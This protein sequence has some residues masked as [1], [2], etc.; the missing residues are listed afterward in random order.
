MTK[1]ERQ[2]VLDQSLPPASG[3]SEHDRPGP[4]RMGA[5]AAAG[6]GG[7]AGGATGDGA[8]T[9]SRTH[10]SPLIARWRS[11]ESLL[12]PQQR[13]PMEK[14]LKLEGLHRVKEHAMDI[15]NDVLADARLKREGFGSSISP[16]TLNFVFSGNPGEDVVD[17]VA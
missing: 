11:I 9:S 7:R 15:Y 5:G 3:S 2:T 16:R 6:V 8:T 12:S 13:E 14:L 17:F 1:A 4:T 10:E